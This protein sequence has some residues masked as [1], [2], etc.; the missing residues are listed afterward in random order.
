MV[1]QVLLLQ[2][3]ILLIALAEAGV[4]HVSKA[5]ALQKF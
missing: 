5:I 1:T 3:H 2:Q 4:E